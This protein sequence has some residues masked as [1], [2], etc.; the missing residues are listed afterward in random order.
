MRSRVGR[1]L[2]SV[3]Q[4]DGDRIGYSPQDRFMM[5]LSYTYLDFALVV[6]RQD[7][8]VFGSEVDRF[9]HRL[10]PVYQ[11]DG[12]RIGYSPQDTFMMSLPADV[13]L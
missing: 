10:G 11:F 3:Y 6:V 13:I 9:G 1:R 5:A 12:D 4:F 7:G 2:G 8:S